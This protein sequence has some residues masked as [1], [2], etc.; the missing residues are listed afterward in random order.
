MVNDAIAARRAARTGS[1]APL[2]RPSHASGPL[3]TAT[4]HAAPIGTQASGPVQTRA[5]AGKG[6]G[7]QGSVLR[8]AGSAVDGRVRHAGTSAASPAA[9]RPIHQG[10]SATSRSMLL[11][12]LLVFVSTATVPAAHQTDTPMI[13]GPTNVR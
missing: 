6:T 1:C 2:A 10:A 4:S 3:P 9:M 13:A 8:R 5:I 7:H 12:V 11:A